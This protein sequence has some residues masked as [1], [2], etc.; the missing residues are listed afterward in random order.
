[1][2]S[3]ASDLPE[4]WQELAKDTLYDPSQLEPPPSQVT[5]ET[6]SDTGRAEHPRV[7]QKVPQNFFHQT[8]PDE[9]EEEERAVTLPLP[10]TSTAVPATERGLGIRK[11]G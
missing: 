1:M 4:D 5:A 10:S 6:T 11:S 2:P 8:D 9:E 7:T 3:F